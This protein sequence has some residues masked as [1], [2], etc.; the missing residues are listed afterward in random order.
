MGKLSV[1]DMNVKDG[2]QITKHQELQSYR[3]TI[4]VLA[5]KST[6]HYAQD[7]YLF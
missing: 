2:K 3:D 6:I 7:I 4:T 5:E 1:N